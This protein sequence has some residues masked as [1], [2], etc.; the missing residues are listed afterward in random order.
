MGYK[1]FCAVGPDK[2]DQIARHKPPGV[3]DDLPVPCLFFGVVGQGYPVSG[4][5]PEQ[6]SGTVHALCR[7]ASHAMRNTEIAPGR[8]NYP[9][10]SGT[11]CVNSFLNPCVHEFT[12]LLTV[13]PA[14]NTYGRGIP[15][16]PFGAGAYRQ[17]AERQK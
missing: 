16:K 1:M 17:Q 13:S 4:K 8:L 14:L 15:V 12:K 9:G 10:G 5:D 7:G 6:Q 3:I 11:A 2:K